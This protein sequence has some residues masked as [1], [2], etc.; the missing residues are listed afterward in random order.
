VP[1]VDAHLRSVNG[2]S[3]R[4]V[5]GRRPRIRISRL[6]LLAIATAT[7]TLI[8]GL[9]GLVQVLKVAVDVARSR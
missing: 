1:G 8:S 3:Q 6:R 9:N 5:P 4:R 2:R 7:A